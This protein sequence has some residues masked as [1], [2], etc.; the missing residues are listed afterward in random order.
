MPNTQLIYNTIFKQQLFCYFSTIK[1]NV[2]GSILLIIVIKMINFFKFLKTLL[3]LI[4][5][6]FK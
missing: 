2:Y 5:N 3:E 6:M 4:L 1:R